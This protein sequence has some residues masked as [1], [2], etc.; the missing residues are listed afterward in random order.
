MLIATSAD[1]KIA[2]SSLPDFNSDTLKGASFI[3][4]S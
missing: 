1:G 3:A 4:Q 2:T